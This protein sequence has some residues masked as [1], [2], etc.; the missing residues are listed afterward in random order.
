MCLNERNRKKTNGSILEEYVVENNPI[1][2]HRPHI[3]V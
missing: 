2:I 1:S 3:K